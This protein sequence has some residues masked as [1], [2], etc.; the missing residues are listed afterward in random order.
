MNVFELREL[1]TLEN[2]PPTEQSIYNMIERVLVTAAQHGATSIRFA[3]PPYML[4]LVK[5]YMEINGFSKVDGL[6]IWF[7]F[8]EPHS[9]LPTFLHGYYE[10]DARFLYN[11]PHLSE[12]HM[13]DYT[14]QERWS[15]I[16][17][18]PYTYP[19]PYI[20]KRFLFNEDNE[21]VEPEND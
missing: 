10:H 14:Y 18:F 20:T 8:E 2:S 15:Q 11:P 16:H 6:N 1:T 13:L 21:L 5:K 12:L 7:W 17:E 3:T 19:E 9:T 4:D